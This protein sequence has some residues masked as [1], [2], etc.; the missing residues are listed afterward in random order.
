[1]YTKKLFP[2]VCLFIFVSCQE[3]I[4]APVPSLYWEAFDAPGSKPLSASALQKLEGIYQVFVSNDDFGDSC[5]VKS[6]YDI[7]GRDTSYYLSFFCK[8]DVRYFILQGKSS[9]DSILLNGYWRN[10]E[11]TKTGKAH[12]IISNRNGAFATITGT[13]VQPGA[14]FIKGW[15]GLFDDDPHK[16]INLQYRKPLHATS[17]FYIIAHRGGGR[18]N[19]LLPASE[20][21]VEMIHLASRLGANS[22]EIDVQLTKDGVPVLF[23]DANLNDRLIKRAGIHKEV[24][25]Y[26]YERLAREVELKRGGKIPTLEDALYTVVYNTPLQFVWLDCKLDGT[27]KSVH[28][29]QEK[30]MQKAKEIGRNVEIVIGVPD[31]DVMQLFL[32]LPG[33][34]VIPSLTEMKQDSAM[35]MKAKI[36]ATTWTKGLQTEDVLAAQAK[37]MRAF[38][39]TLDVPR[40]IKEFMREGRFNGITT[41]RPSA[42]AYEYYSREKY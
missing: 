4:D 7:S 22:I 16:E 42:V 25:H 2:I 19:D 34:N 13:S 9:G 15:Y 27:L 35:K 1:M 18:N 26:T 24:A 21:S 17:P 29:L 32:S 6:T 31:K 30:Y 14:I 28:A 12:F 10:V 36:W 38:A 8:E 11:N 33:Y 23:H 40:K 37:G 41:N 20:N 3:I 39:W 5:V